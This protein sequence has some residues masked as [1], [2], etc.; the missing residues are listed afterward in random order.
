MQKAKRNKVAQIEH[1]Q[2]LE[3]ELAVLEPKY[4]RELE[5]RTINKSKS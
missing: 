5:M 4:A 1:A 2:K 3:Q